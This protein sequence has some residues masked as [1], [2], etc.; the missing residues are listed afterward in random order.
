MRQIVSGNPLRIYAGYTQEELYNTQTIFNI[1]VKHNSNFN[2]KIILAIMN[3]SLINF[4]HAYKYLDLSKNLF[5]KILIQNC[6]KFPIPKVEL[7]NEGAVVSIIEVVDQILAAKKQLQQATTEGDKNYLNRKCEILDKQIDEL[8][9][10]LYGL[11]EEEIKI[12]EGK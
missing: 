1:L 5:Q 9:Y 4:Y 10:N 3:S 11:T 2:T 8:V 6:K 7:N 12:V